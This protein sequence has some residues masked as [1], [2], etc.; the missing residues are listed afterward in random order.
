MFTVPSAESVVT[1]PSRINVLTPTGGPGFGPS[2]KVE[3][4]KIYPL[5]FQKVTGAVGSGRPVESTVVRSVPIDGNTGGS[6]M[7]AVRKN[8]ANKS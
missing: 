3:F 2:S 6:A 1:I 5:L 4:N 8:A 7:P